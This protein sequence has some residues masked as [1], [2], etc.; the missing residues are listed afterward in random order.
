MRRLIAERD[1]DAAS[2]RVAAA[3]RGDGGGERHILR[4]TV[5][6]NNHYSWACRMRNASYHGRML[7]APIGVSAVDLRKTH[8][9][10]LW[11]T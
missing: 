1:T 6:V 4:G 8:L 11:C 2:Q 10:S 9:L 5:L 7:H 3:G